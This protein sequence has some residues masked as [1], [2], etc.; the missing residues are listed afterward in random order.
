MKYVW[1]ILLLAG[2][3]HPLDQ[4]DG[5]DCRQYIKHAVLYE[6]PLDSTF[7][8]YNDYDYIVSPNCKKEM[9]EARDKRG[10]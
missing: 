10:W 6:L 3:G 7:V 2:C 4:I 5:E 8:K 9:L 1:L